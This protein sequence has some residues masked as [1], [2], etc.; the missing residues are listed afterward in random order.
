MEKDTAPIR[1]TP[2]TPPDAEIVVDRASPPSNNGR[3]RDNWL[4]AVTQLCEDPNT[5]DY[6]GKPKLWCR[7]KSQDPSTGKR[8]AH[9]WSKPRNR[10]RTA[11][12]I[13]VCRFQSIAHQEEAERILAEEAT[14]EKADN[15]RAKEDGNIA[16]MWKKRS[17]ADYK[18]IAD[19]AV[20]KFICR[21]GLAPYT[22][23][24]AAWAEFVCDLSAGRY[25]SMSGTSL[26]EKFIA[27]EAARVREKTILYLKSDA[28]QYITYGF[29][30]GATRRRR[31]F[32]TIHA[33]DQDR[34][35]HFLAAEDTS[36]LAHTSELYCELVLKVSQPCIQV[37]TYMTHD[38]LMCVDNPPV[39]E[40]N[41][42]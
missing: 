28:V 21:L 9:L 5:I 12:H 13:R 29:D 1:K 34:R 39:H 41:W 24:S 8:C 19:H 3:N 31:S 38:P 32:L 37:M 42:T 26:T 20:V 35:A 15:A 6:D 40:K 36:G 4:E 25:E 17:D 23:D 7:C 10:D 30:G 18:A 22:V 33:T 16:D 14:G 27:G 11:R 2:Q